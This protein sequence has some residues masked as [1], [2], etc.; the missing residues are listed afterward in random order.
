VALG[1][2]GTYMHAL[3]VFCRCRRP[4]LP[5]AQ[6]CDVRMAFRLGQA[7]GLLC[8][9]PCTDRFWWVRGGLYR[10]NAFSGLMLS[11]RPWHAITVAGP[12]GMTAEGSQ[13]DGARPVCHGGRRPPSA[14]ASR[15]VSSGSWPT[16]VRSACL[17]KSATAR[18]RMLLP[19][20]GRRSAHCVHTV[21]C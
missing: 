5:Y 18:R 12:Q 21:L 19:L 6:S 16:P 17:D 20:D 2:A 3:Y 11:S 13:Q 7:Q 14:K 8:L 9:P 15:S 4:C 1:E 10:V